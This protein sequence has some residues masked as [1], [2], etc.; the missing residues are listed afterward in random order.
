[1]IQ[2]KIPLWAV[3]GVL[4]SPLLWAQTAQKIETLLDTPAITWAGA[5]VFA[6]EAADRAVFSNPADAFAYAAER[7]WLPK[8][9]APQDTAR[10]NGIALLLM[11]S[12]DIKGGIFYSL[13]KNPHYAYRELVYREV[14]EGRIDPD[15]TVSGEDFL[16]YINRLFA[17]REMAAE[18]AAKREIKKPETKK[19]ETAPASKAEEQLARDINAQLEAQHVADT[20]ARVTSEG[21]TISLSNIQFRPNSAELLDSEKAK[22]REIAR[23]LEN[24]PERN[25]L[26]TGHTA[27]AGTREEQQR[28]SMERARTVAFYLVSIGARTAEEIT[29]R[30]YGAE[31]PMVSNDTEAGRIQNRRVEITI[32]HTENRGRRH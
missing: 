7:K 27:L 11:G 31:Q 16:Y 28:T 15:M 13:A 19:T 24:V 4:F 21:V 30:G 32:V 20:S 25:I 8:D 6:L 17:L 10:L 1:M 9:A 23:I 2:P 3:L 18:R 29:I 5:A 12:F 14:I 22:L 26:V